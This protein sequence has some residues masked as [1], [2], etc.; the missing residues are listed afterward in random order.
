M[1]PSPFL[2]RKFSTSSTLPQQKR[3]VTDSL[4]FSCS[5]SPATIAGP[6]SFCHVSVFSLSRSARASS[7][8]IFDQLALNIDVETN[9]SHSALSCSFNSFSH[10]SWSAKEPLSLSAKF[11]AQSELNYF[12]KFFHLAAADENS[13]TSSSF[14][15]SI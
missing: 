14:F 15:E 7:T 4:I 5:L 8:A 6:W 13:K 11:S 10:C 3:Q 12:F 1:E 9:G 2:L